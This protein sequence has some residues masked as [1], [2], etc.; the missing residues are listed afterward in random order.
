MNHDLSADEISFY[1]DNGY[2]I[3][4]DFLTAEE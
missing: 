4:H 1:Q 3:K 2:L